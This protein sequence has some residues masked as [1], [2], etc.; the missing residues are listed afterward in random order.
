MPLPSKLFFIILLISGLLTA[1]YAAPLGREELQKIRAFLDEMREVTNAYISLLKGLLEKID[2]RYKYTQEEMEG[3]SKSLPLSSNDHG[4]GLQ[5]Q[6]W[7]QVWRMAG[8]GKYKG[9]DKVDLIIKSL[10]ATKPAAAVLGEVKALKLI[11]DLVDFGT[12]AQGQ[13]TIIM[14]R[15]EGVQLYETEAYKKASGQKKGEMAKETARLGC[16]KSAEDA[17]HKGVWHNDNHMYNILVVEV[18]DESV[19]SVELVDYGEGSNY[20]V[21]GEARNP[22]YIS[23]YYDWCIHLYGQ[24]I[25]VF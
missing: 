5:N 18:R 16:S 8:P 24:P 19:K 14:K 22:E 10:P 7:G 3:L 21:H 23:K 15:K 9:H 1:T 2:D 25:G 11:G 4:L 12:N 20:L 6:T 17:F 13:P